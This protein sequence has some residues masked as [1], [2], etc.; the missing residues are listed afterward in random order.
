M[1]HPLTKAPLISRVK[2]HLKQLSPRG[3]S[4]LQAP[5]SS[6][7]FQDSRLTRQQAKIKNIEV[8]DH[9]LPSRLLERKSRK[10]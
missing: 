6:S 2:G 5:F 7:Q 10:K 4:K 3:I 8:P 9:P 1:P